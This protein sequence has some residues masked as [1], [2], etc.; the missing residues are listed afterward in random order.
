MAASQ[1]RRQAQKELVRVTDRSVSPRAAHLPR[2]QF[3]PS[4]DGGS[5]LPASMQ[6]C[7]LQ[8]AE[9]LPAM[10][11]RSTV[12]LDRPLAAQIHCAEPAWE[13]RTPTAPSHQRT[14]G[15]FHARKPWHSGQFGLAAI[16]SAQRQVGHT[17]SLS[18]LVASALW[19]RRASGA[20]SQVSL[21]VGLVL[22]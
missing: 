16:P 8:G 17:H 4:R 22:R 21:G 5:C 2:H 10:L 20:A 18:E 7:S 14:L 9:P 13:L 3:R 6:K 12:F 1:S 15:R 11:K 19:P